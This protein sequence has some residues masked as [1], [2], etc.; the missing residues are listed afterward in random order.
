MQI[1]V[2]VIATGLVAVF[3]YFPPAIAFTQMVSALSAATKKPSLCFS[4]MGHGKFSCCYPYFGNFSPLFRSYTL[5]TRR[6]DGFFGSSCMNSWAVAAATVA[7]A[8]HGLGAIPSSPAGLI[9]VVSHAVCHPAHQFPL[10]TRR[11]RVV[12]F[13]ELAM[14]FDK[15]L[16]LRVPSLSS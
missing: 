5:F 4:T 13:F 7:Y 11:T 1:Q 14:S 3:S 10:R 15:L 8:M 9:D 2:S 12:G 6:R 16:R